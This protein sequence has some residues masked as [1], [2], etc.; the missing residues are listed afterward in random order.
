MEA[1]AFDS[2]NVVK[3]NLRA[4][5]AKYTVAEMAL[6]MGC[7]RPTLSRFIN[8]DDYHND[9]IEA[10]AMEFLKKELGITQ[11][12]HAAAKTYKKSIEDMGFYPT[13]NALMAASVLDDCMK[14]HY[15]E[16]GLGLI[17]GPAGAGKTRSVREFA[18]RYPNQVVHIEVSE[19][20]ALKDLLEEIGEELGIRDKVAYGSAHSRAKKIA[21]F[22]SYDPRMIVIDE[23]DKLVT[24]DSVRKIETIRW[25]QDRSKAPIVL[26][27]L[28]T[29]VP[30]LYRGPSRKENLSQLYSRLGGVAILDGL[31]KDDAAGMLNGY[32]ITEDAK[33]ELIKIG[34]NKD[35][36]CARAL[37]KT[38]RRCLYLAE[39]QT[40]TLEIVKEAER[41]VFP[42]DAR[43]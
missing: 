43:F 15:D 23:V 38:L 12:E 21:D 11:D 14:Y 26:V 42:R 34:T 6:Q 22:L 4:L 10:K 3:D 16:L 17:V 24:R 39:G 32:D 36:G 28:P 30:Y 2:V 19:N 18:K 40:V 5:K 25:I 7:Q 1:K 13:R 41:L 9:E 8:E 27:G 35:S 20:M 29:M 31:T 37:V 33:D